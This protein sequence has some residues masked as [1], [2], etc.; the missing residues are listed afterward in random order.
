M[1]FSLILEIVLTL[2]AVFMAIVLHEVAHGYMAYRLGDPTAKNRGRLTLNP[3]A[4]VDLVGTILVPVGLILMQFLF[5]FGG[6]LF[7]W[8]KPVPISPSYFRN[9]L[10][11]MLYVA[12]AG[13]GTNIAL[14]LG[15]VVVGHV[16][17]LLIPDQTS[18]T[19][20]YGVQTG[21]V[22]PTFGQNMLAALFFVLAAFALYNL[23]LAAFN[24]L[25][26]PPL[27]GSRVL[28]YFLSPRGR[29]FLISIERYGFFLLIGL[30]YLRVLDPVFN[31]IW[32]LWQ[33]LLGEEWLVW[34][35]LFR[36]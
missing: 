25:P 5:N 20:F 2:L 15:T 18:T 17:L 33:G 11:G 27:D 13:P 34:R 31:G 35:F 24:L 21:Q 36:V 10:R 16:V 26:I 3:L 29:R 23:I 6:V 8:A 7:G 1:D 19:L 22:I 32:S 28:M 4:H 9:P 14:A 30:L 12:L